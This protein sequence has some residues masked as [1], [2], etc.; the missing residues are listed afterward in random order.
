MVSD[1]VY[2]LCLPVLKDSTLEEEEKTDKLEELLRNETTL[3]GRPLEDAILGA[4]WRYRD[5]T[6]PPA[7]SPPV[8]PGVPRKG[9]PAPWQIPRSSTPLASPPLS[10]VSPAPGPGYGIAPPA[11]TRAKSSTASPFTSP[12]PSPRLAFASH[13]PHS[14][15][16]NSYEF[17]EPNAQNTDY[18]DYGSDTVDWLVS[19]DSPSRPSSSGAGSN[20]ESVLSG[21]AATWI[22]PQ[23]TDMSPHDML[24]SILGDGRSDEE[25]ETALEANSYDLSSTIMAL[26]GNQ[27][28]FGEQTALHSSEGQVLIGKSMTPSEPI[29]I[30]QHNQGRSSVI[31]KYWLSTGNCLRADCRFSHDLS[32]HICKYV[33]DFY[34]F[35]RLPV[36]TVHP[37]YNYSLSYLCQQSIA[38]PSQNAFTNCIIIG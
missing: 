22:Q 30:N 2:E 3:S 33:N 19:D 35:F 24:R 38:D 23:Q 12:R 25:I 26:M 27:T 18:G 10:G 9:S 34:N 20:Q 29:A 1:K 8:R 4:L 21:A 32:S 5:V 16:L 37:V 7:I 11:F 17:S 13:I 31:C 6:N 28:M 14:P 36:F 15:N